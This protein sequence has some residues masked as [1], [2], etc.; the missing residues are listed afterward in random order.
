M[1]VVG[2][3][4]FRFSGFPVSLFSGFPVSL[5][6]SFPFPLFPNFPIPMPRIILLL[7]LLLS[8]CN[9]P[10]PPAAT[11]TLDSAAVATI[12]AATLSAIRAQTPAA[13]P[14]QPPAAAPSP[15]PGPTASI[16]PSS[17]ANATPN[18]PAAPLGLSYT[19]ACAYGGGATLTLTWQ[20]TA[21]N[22]DGYRIYRDG[23]LLGQIA[24]NTSKYNDSLPGYSGVFVYRVEAFNLT[25]GAPAQVTVTL[26]C[27]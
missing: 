11:P 14:T 26:N 7:V 18:P 17:T 27:Q 23:I 19:F 15:T 10:Q 22:E 12:A 3:P 21:S 8:A 16:T 6:S 13:T 5:F 2:F 24:A 25:G 1:A 20:D 4:V 9:L